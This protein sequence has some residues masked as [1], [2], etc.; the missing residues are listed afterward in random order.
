MS[1]SNY[2][3]FEKCLKEGDFTVLILKIPLNEVEDKLAYFV[4]DKGKISRSFFEDYVIATTVANINQLLHH[5][6]VLV[7][8]LKEPGA[9]L[10][11][12]HSLRALTALLYGL[13][14][15]LRSP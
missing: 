12:G 7:A 2:E 8:S 1:K 13:V 6:S 14:P 15:Y 5:L 9:V 3:V 10:V 11:M 4:R